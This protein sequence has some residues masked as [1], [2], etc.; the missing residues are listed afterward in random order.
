MLDVDSRLADR[1]FISET[2]EQL[3]MKFDIGVDL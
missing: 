2:A 3:L 1:N